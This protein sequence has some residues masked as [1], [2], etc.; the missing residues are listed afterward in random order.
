MRLIRYRDDH[1]EPMLAP[2]RS[3]LVGIPLGMSQ[4]EDE[5]DLMAIE[6]VY[7]LGGGEFPRPYR[8]LRFQPTVAEEHSG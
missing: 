1:L 6:Q 4:Q 5:A 2:H 7:F 3:A 8:R